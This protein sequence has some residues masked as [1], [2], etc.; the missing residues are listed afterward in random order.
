M[1]SN[2]PDKIQCFAT[3]EHPYALALALTVP[4]I[5]N[6]LMRGGGGGVGTPFKLG[7]L[8]NEKKTF[9]SISEIIT[10]VFGSAVRNIEVTSG[11]Q[12][13]NL[14][15]CY[16]SPEIAIISETITRKKTQKNAAARKLLTVLFWRQYR[17]N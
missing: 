2:Y 13:S 6:H 16:I 3:P 10:E 15:K 9:K 14:A 17:Q 12:R 7:S 11:H 4:W 8:R 5:F 1:S